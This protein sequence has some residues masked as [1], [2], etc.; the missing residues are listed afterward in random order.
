MHLSR[1]L[2][3]KKIGSMLRLFTL[4][5]LSLFLFSCK[6]ESP[7]TASKVKYECNCTPLLGATLSGT[8]TYA[9]PTSTNN[10]GSLANNTWSF[11]QE[12]W[13]L[14]SGD[15]VTAAASIQGNS[16]CTLT[17][18]VNDAIKTFRSQRVEVSGQNPT[19]NIT[20]EYIVP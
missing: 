3:S 8:I 12:R 6:K 11:T 5:T 16:N 9:T 13:T 10:S 14:K 4:V 18:F 20:V 2:L 15:K 7:A 17:I 1:V 19:N